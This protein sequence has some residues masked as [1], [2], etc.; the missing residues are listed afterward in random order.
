MGKLY[1]NCDWKPDCCDENKKNSV[2]VVLGVK[3][4]SF[5]SGMLGVI[6]VFSSRKDAV[7]Y[8]KNNDIIEM[9]L[10]SN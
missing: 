5:A 2:Y 4:L 10:E 3:K 9:T 1:K 8:S 7:T 6:P